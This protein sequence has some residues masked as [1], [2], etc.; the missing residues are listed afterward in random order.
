MR[1]CKAA[2]RLGSAVQQQTKEDILF[3]VVMA[4][5]MTYLDILFANSDFC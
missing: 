3:H 4:E 2:S 1:G 5:M